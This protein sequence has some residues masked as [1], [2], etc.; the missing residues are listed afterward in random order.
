[1]AE[2]IWR[3]G[4]PLP[5]IDDHSRAKLR[6]FDEYLGTYFP[7]VVRT[8]GMPR[9]NITIVDGFCGGGTYQGR[10][11]LVSG[12]PFVLLNAVEKAQKILSENRRAP[13][14]LDA[15]FH[16]VDENSDAVDHLRS[17]LVRNGYLTRL[18]K[19]IIVHRGAFVD[20]YPEIKSSIQAR[21]RNGVGRSIFILDQKGYKDAPIETIRDIM[22][23]FRAAEVLLTFA[24]DHLI[25]HISDSPEFHKAVVPLG[26]L[27]N[28]VRSWLEQKHSYGQNYMRYTVQRFLK[29][30]LLEA[31][32][33]G[34][35]SPFFLH[36]TKS[37]KDMWV[38]HLSHH[39]TAR[40]VMVDSHYKIFTVSRHPGNGGIEIMGYDPLMDP[41]LV[42]DFLFNSLDI[43]RSNSRLRVDIE[44]LIHDNYSD[45]GV[46]Y[47][48]F[49]GQIAN[50]TPARLIDISDVVS[51][52]VADGYLA[53]HTNDGGVKR[54]NAPR[55]SDVLSL[56][57]Q[58]SLF[59][60]LRSRRRSGAD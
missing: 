28:H 17:E 5:V 56:V 20:I 27:P 52:S 21:T 22:N 38:V 43:E 44:R 37:S 35:I 3:V 29:S 12:S 8:P 34:F 42:G 1:M 26:I 7:T 51:E 47:A 48:M 24:V 31:S 16:F 57:G 58:K 49:I 11:E 45:S 33:A 30:H 40:N 55:P 19:D 4:G 59:P 41:D 39:P 60:Q 23:S 53:L 2:F 32:G 14:F 13:F 50:L 36:S 15:V 10:G 18:G 54:S 9:L 6:L 25:D 46:N